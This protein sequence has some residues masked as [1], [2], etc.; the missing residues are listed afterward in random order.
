MTARRALALAAL[1]AAARAGGGALP[2]RYGGEIRVALTELPSD[3]DPARA[4]TPAE[5][6]AARA[7]HATLVELLPSGELRPGLLAG[8]PEAEAGGRAFRMRLRPGLRFQDGQPLLAADVAASLSR[9]LQPAVRSPHAWLALAIQGA[10][11][12]REGR[13]ASLAGVQVLSDLDLRVALDVPIDLPRALAAA[14]AAI[15]SR[16]GAGAGPFRPGGRGDG[17]LRLP[18]FDDCPSGRAYPDAL[19][20]TGLD[21]RRAARAFSRGEIDLV[22]RPD[23]APGAAAGELPALTATYALVN[24][25]R[26]GALAA[27]LRRRLAELDRGELTRLFVRGPALPLSG[28][29]PPAV[30]AA[31]APPAPPAARLPG[32]PPRRL[33]L[34][35]SSAAEN[36]RAVADRIQVKLFDRGVRVVVESLAPPAFAARLAAGD[37]DLALAA[38]TFASAS[39][40][41]ATLQLAQALGGVPLARRALARLGEADAA[42]VAAEVVEAAGAV[43]L[44]AVGL[45][46]SARPGLEGL[47]PRPDGTLD[48]GGLWTLRAAL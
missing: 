12:V 38:V 26:R 42:A 8:L 10:E 2:P 5:L 44:F 41:L 47:A 33:S 20:L 25:R 31:V 1:L 39:P 22:L 48:P 13:A 16:S 29:L 43:P 11:A 46:A 27:P 21:A 15:V 17:T 30:L 19:V 40:Q 37:W 3:L 6:L 45:R 4:S 24:A 35:V 18:A 9:L 34:L 7:L 28:P 36:H 32:A 14:P 23:A